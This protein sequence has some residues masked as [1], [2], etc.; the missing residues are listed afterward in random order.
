[1]LPALR[2]ELAALGRE[3]IMVVIGGVIPPDDVVTLRE[4]GAA[5]VFL[6]GAV[7]ADS[8]LSL[9]GRLSASLGHESTG[10]DGS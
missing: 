7:I 9:L 3:D 8:A 4:M 5:E 2:E 6:P 1:M 10:A